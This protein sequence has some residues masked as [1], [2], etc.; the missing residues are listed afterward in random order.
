MEI[1]LLDSERFEVQWLPGRDES[2]AAEI[3]RRLWLL[4][5]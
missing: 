3:V 4:R 1:N 2:P 5:R